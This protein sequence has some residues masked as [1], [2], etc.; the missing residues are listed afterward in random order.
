MACDESK[1]FGHSSMP[2]AACGE[3]SKILNSS[4]HTRGWYAKRA[5]IVQVFKYTAS[6][7]NMT[8]N[9]IGGARNHAAA[10]TRNTGDE[11]EACFRAAEEAE[12][13]LDFLITDLPISKRRPWVY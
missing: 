13:V 1:A 9:A 2:T 12:A 10:D 3:K 6:A 8:R 4:A 5:E 7:G 11:A